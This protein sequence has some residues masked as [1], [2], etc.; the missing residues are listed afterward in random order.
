MQLLDV[1]Q[2]AAALRLSQRQC[3]NLVASGRLPNP[4]RIGRSVRWR[5]ADIARFVDLGCDAD[6]F[7]TEAA[8]AVRHG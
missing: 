7:A 8:K 5:A 3:W 2:V 4:I 6:R 1:R